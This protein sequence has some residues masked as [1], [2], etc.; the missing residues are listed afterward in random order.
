M[1][2]PDQRLVAPCAL[3]FALLLQGC[4]EPQDVRESELSTSATPLDGLDSD[5]LARFRKGAGE[6]SEIESVAE[7]LG[8]FFNASSC[9]HCH[10]GAGLGGGGVARVTRVMC[11][12]DEGELD[13]P[14][15]GQLLHSFSTRPDVAGPGIPANCDAVVADRRTTNALGAGLIEAIPDEQILAEETAQ[16]GGASGRAALVDDAFRGGQRVG[17]FGWKAQHAT[18]DAFSADAYRNEM[19]IT[20]EIFTDEVVPA[21]D[22]DLLASMDSVPDPEAPVGAVSALADFMRFSAP[23]Q[24]TGDAEPGLGTFR[25]IGCVACHRETYRTSDGASGLANRDVRLFS[26]LLLHDIGTGD[27]IPQA[28]ALESEIRTPPLWGLGRASFFLHDGS[29]ASIDEAVLAHSGQAADAASAY[30][31]LAESERLDLLAF[32]EAL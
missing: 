12:S 6:F 21:G 22:Q 27:G 9:G 5:E 16:R 29:A 8:P 10:A 28:A 14:P 32:L 7:G 3:L 4:E 30:A 11:R 26:D 1:P 23:F 15:A 18:L 2:K 24:P 20:N 25:S 31:A 19:G 17:R 13:A